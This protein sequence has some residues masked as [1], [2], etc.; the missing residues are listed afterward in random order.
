MCRLLNVPTTIQYLSLVLIL[1]FVIRSWAFG[2]GSD[3]DAAVGQKRI[4]TI[5]TNILAQ[6]NLADTPDLNATRTINDDESR[7]ILA[8]YYALR[9]ASESLEKE[10]ERICRSQDF[11]A[12]PVT[13]FAALSPPPEDVLGTNSSRGRRD[14]SNVLNRYTLYFN[15]DLPE[16]RSDISRA[17]LLLYQLQSKTGPGY[18]VLDKTQYV[19]V[20]AF[21]KSL[22]IQTTAEGKYVNVSESGYQ[23]FDITSTVKLWV[24]HDVKGPVSFEVTIHCYSSL[25]CNQ[26]T[27]GLQPTQVEF[28]TDS[29]QQDKTP[30]LLT[31]SNSV[32]DNAL[33]NARRKREDLG[34]NF[35]VQPASYVANYCGGVC[36]RSAGGDTMTPT[37]YEF[38]SQLSS[39]NPGASV[40]PC[41]A[42]NTY[43]PLEVLIQ[44]KGQLVIEEL[45]QVI[46]TSCRCT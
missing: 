36:P 33:K 43:L 3:S 23:V 44:N 34:F 26:K 37:L 45:Q 27:S 24:S 6:L 9:N 21:A 7:T 31:I 46:V 40:Q 18:T 5:R 28:F 17:D 13:S 30:R 15:F 35:I 16:N 39:G 38:L 8:A 11:F 20:N 4:Q 19:E 2:C 25:T 1:C 10:R 42:G 32:T 41:C 12:K 29:T 22:G 14:A